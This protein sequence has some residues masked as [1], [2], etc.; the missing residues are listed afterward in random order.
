M[1]LGS[2]LADLLLFPSWLLVDMLFRRL[3]QRQEA[4]A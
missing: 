4:S 2:N 3:M 1:L